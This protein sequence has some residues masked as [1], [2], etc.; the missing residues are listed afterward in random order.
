M[1]VRGRFCDG[2][3]ASHRDLASSARRSSE[4]LRGNYFIRC[5]LHVSLFVALDLS[6]S[7]LTLRVCSSDRPEEAGFYV[8]GFQGN[9]PFSG[10]FATGFR[11]FSGDLVDRFYSLRF[12]F[13]ESVS[14]D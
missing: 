3:S 10:R 8:S 12:R 13:G 14:V 7:S 2:C 4:R 1:L 6:F 5:R 11:K 9:L